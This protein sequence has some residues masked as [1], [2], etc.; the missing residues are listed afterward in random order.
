MEATIVIDPLFGDGGKGAAVDWLAWAHHAS[1]V[2]RY[3]GGAQASHTVVTPEGNKYSFGML[4]SASFQRIPTFLSKYVR[5]DMR[6]LAAELADFPDALVTLDPQAVLVTP[7]QVRESQKNAST[8]KKGTTGM[9]VG[10]SGR[11]AEDHPE[12]TLHAFDLFSEGVLY[13]KLKEQ[14]SHYGDGFNLIGMVQSYQ[15]I[16]RR[17]QIKDWISVAADYDYNHVIF[18]GSAGV[19]LDPVEGMKPH[20]TSTRTTS[21]NAWEM[22]NAIG[23]HGKKV[24]TVGVLPIFG[25]RHG[26]GYFPTEDTRLKK[27]IPTP[28]LPE[29]IEG[30]GAVRIGWLDLPLISRGCYLGIMDQ[31][32]VSHL[33]YFDRIPVWRVF[34]KSGWEYFREL[35]EYIDY[36]ERYL[37]LPITV[38]AKGPK[39]NDRSVREQVRLLKTRG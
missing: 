38:T 30:Q 35:P 10:E 27:H 37:N 32:H 14:Q 25:Q 34:T 28:D 31:L 21:V 12:S 22:L 19:L 17:L 29:N 13:R 8:S 2:V 16:A 15:Q 23:L 4:G 26:P 6:V 7:Y 11:Y 20:V 39:R 9:G 3:N 5:V 1:L 36:I 18:E 33:D 24:H